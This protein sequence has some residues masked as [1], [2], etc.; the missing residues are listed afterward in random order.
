MATCPDNRLMPEFIA[1]LARFCGA[2]RG[3]VTALARH[4]GVAQPHVSAWLT[5]RQEPS[6]EHTLR[7]QEWLAS[8]REGK[9]VAVAAG[10]RP[11]PARSRVETQPAAEPVPVWLL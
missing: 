4:L 10:S 11:R 5:G 9:S 7:I 6:G 3:R 1:E 2:K 8:E